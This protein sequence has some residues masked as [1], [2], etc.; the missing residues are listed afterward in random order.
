MRKLA[1][2]PSG[3][4]GRWCLRRRHGEPRRARRRSDER[5]PSG[6]GRGARWPGHRGAGRQ[7]TQGSIARPDRRA[8]WPFRRTFDTEAGRSGYTPSCCDSRPF[9]PI[10]HRLPARRRRPHRALQL[11]ARPP[12]RRRVRAAHRGHR[13][14]AIV[15]RDG[16]R[17]PAGD[18]LARPGLGRRARRRR[19][20]RTV[21]P[22]AALRSAPR[23]RRAARRGRPRLLR[24]HAAREVRRG[25]QGRRGAR[26]GVA[27]RPRRV[28]ARPRRGARA[29]RERRAAGDPLQ[30]AG[31]P[32]GLHR[33]RQGAGRVRQHG[34]RRL[35]HRP[36]RRPADL[37]PVGGLR[38]RGHGDH[39]RDPRRR[40]RVEHAEARAAVHRDG[41]AGAGLRAR[42][43]DPRAR[44]EAPEQAPRRHVGARVQG[45]GLP[46]RGDAQLPRAPRL[47]A[48]RRQRAALDRRPDRA[49]RARRHRLGQRGVQHREAGLGEQPAHHAHGHARAGP[50]RRAVPARRRPVGR[51]LRRRR[52]RSG[53]APSS[54]SSSRARSGCPSS[55]SGAGRSSP[56]SPSTTRRRRRSCG[57]RPRRATC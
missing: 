21:L 7:R 29:G 36:P 28:G 15:G 53:S 45:A 25:A 34:D 18:A 46:A 32:D 39:A 48:R 10:A 26:R 52:A 41:C 50:P 55:S 9:R 19:A 43:D 57:P 38:R 51:R 20:A 24:L 13:R 4:I 56:T 27:L 2:S 30:G 23:R 35:R 11:A 22:V 31:G 42:A 14:R 16:R 33:P 5:A 49:L 8:Q 6:A 44:Q 40:P 54:I 1:G 17:H 3:H 47:V 12:R 37:P